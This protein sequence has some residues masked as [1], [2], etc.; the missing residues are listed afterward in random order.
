MT[1]AATLPEEAVN[2]NSRNFHLSSSRDTIRLMSTYQE[3]LAYLEHFTNAEPQPDSPQAMDAA[4][5]LE[6]MRRLLAELGDPHL[7]YPVAMH[8]AGTKGKGSV[9]AICASVLQAAG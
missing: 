8:V 7:R 4:L 5:N 3:V 2:F 6:R 1:A 9:S